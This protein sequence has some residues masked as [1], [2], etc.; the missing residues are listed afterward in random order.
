MTV[1]ETLLSGLVRLAFRFERFFPYAV[2]L[3]VNR[4]LGG[5][6]NAGQITDYQI[7]AERRGRYHYLFQIDL[8]LNED[9]VREVIARYERKSEDY[10]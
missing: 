3:F 10:H 7:K 4:K 5:Y 9:N 2:R 8:T 6:K 1:M